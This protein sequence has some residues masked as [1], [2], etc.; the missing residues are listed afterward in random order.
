MMKGFLFLSGIQPI[1][2][3]TIQGVFRRKA[4]KT[5]AIARPRKRGTPNGEDTQ[6]FLI[7]SEIAR[8][9]GFP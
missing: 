5:G 4:A 2:K 9:K 8:S 6:Q 7:R 1:G 3:G